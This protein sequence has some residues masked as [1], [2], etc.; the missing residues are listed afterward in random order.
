[1]RIWLLYHTMNLFLSLVLLF[2]IFVFIFGWYGALIVVLI[3]FVSLIIYLTI[4]YN[5]PE[6]KELRRANLR[7]AREKAKNGDSS[8]ED[9]DSIERRQLYSSPGISV[10]IST[11]ETRAYD[12]FPELY[13]KRTLRYTDPEAAAS[14]Y[15]KYAPLE[16]GLYCYHQACM[17]YRDA[18]LPSKEK[19]V[20]DAVLD[21]LATDGA[22]EMV[23]EIYRA[24][25]R[26]VNRSI[27]KA[28]REKSKSIELSQFRIAAEE[29]LK[30]LEGRGAIEEYHKVCTSYRMAKMPHEEKEVILRIM[31]MIDENPESARLLPIYTK[32][33]SVV[34]RLI[35]N[36]EK[37]ETPSM[38]VRTERPAAKPA[39]K[40]PEHHTVVTKIPDYTTMERDSFT[41]ID[42]ETATS[43]RLACQVGIVVVENGTVV[44]KITA[45]IQPPNNKYDIYCSQV[46]GVTAAETES[47]P[48]FDEV[49]EYIAPYLTETRVV[50]HNAKFDEDVLRKNLAHYGIEAE[51]YPFVCT[52]DIFNRMSLKS[53]CQGFEMPTEGHHNALFDAECCAEFYLRYLDGE[54]PDMSLVDTPAPKKAKAPTFAGHKALSGD[55][56]KKD[57]SNADP[58]NPFYDKKIVITGVLTQDRKELATLLKEHGADIDTS[59]SKLTDMVIIGSACGP[60]K[61]KKIEALNEGGCNIRKIY[62]E[63]LDQLLSTL[64]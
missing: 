14:M 3:L 8:A 17:C 42:F 9:V 59:I 52:C 49:W 7:A 16:D 63:E 27:A 58:S 22:D 20:V 12:K 34:E 64:G 19:E 4:D 36:K 11:E 40:V 60:A 33:L 28:E 61:M 56:L 13:E 23:W 55:V 2:F 32:R 47:S 1:M 43:S 21:V 38:P 30:A 45:L 41:A 6:Y 37:R 51:V 46:H 29:Q 31:A 62:Q 53:L 15:L 57:L 18:K 24:R 54:E 39:A 50:A 48:L 5:K 44:N 25:L 26:S 35:A 10:S